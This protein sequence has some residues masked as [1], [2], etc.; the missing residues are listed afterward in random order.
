M[1]V[2]QRQALVHLIL[3]MPHIMYIHGHV[4]TPIHVCLY[5]QGIFVSTALSLS[6]QQDG[7]TPVYIASTQGRRST[8][9]SFHV[10]FVS[11]FHQQRSQI[12]PLGKDHV[13]I[14]QMLIKAK[15]DINHPNK[16]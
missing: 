8:F 7:Q 5:V 9:K 13:A 6:D 3:H 15:A 10:P 14:I 11:H 2:V 4:C 1:Y 12:P 16:V